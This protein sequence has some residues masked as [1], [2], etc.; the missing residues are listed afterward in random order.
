MNG[1]LWLSVALAGLLGCKF[2]STAVR[3]P[4]NASVLDLENRIV[5]PFQDQTAKAIVLFFIRTDCPISNRY[6]PEIERLAATYGKKSIAFWLIYPEA[7]TSPE[8]I[9]QHCKEYQLSLKPLRDPRHALVKLARVTVTPEAAVFLPDGSEIYRGRIDNRYVDFGK[10]RPA[11]TIR[12]L[13]EALKSVI[14]GKPVV[15]SV[16]RAVGCYIE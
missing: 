4:S 12:D 15:S 10:E 14:G 2:D 16:T 7:E 11:P 1:T 3:G 6:A 5:N 13:D 9:E 8:K